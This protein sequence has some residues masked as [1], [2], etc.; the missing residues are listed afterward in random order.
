MTHAALKKVPFKN[1]NQNLL[2]LAHAINSKYKQ[3]HRHIESSIFNRRV[4][5]SNIQNTF[6]K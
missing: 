6:D 3:I 5:V 2:S 1:L 4:A